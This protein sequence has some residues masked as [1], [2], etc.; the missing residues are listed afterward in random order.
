MAKL[1]A[2][3]NPWSAKG[4]YA[5][6]SAGC[7]VLDNIAPNGT[8]WANANPDVAAE[9]MKRLAAWR[10]Y[11][12]SSVAVSSNGT[13]VSGDA[14]SLDAI[15]PSHSDLNDTVL[16]ALADPLFNFSSLVQGGGCNASDPMSPLFRQSKHFRINGRCAECPVGDRS[17]SITG[18]AMDNRVFFGLWVI[19]LLALITVRVGNQLGNLGSLPILFNFFATTSLFAHFAPVEG[20]SP[21]VLSIY[22]VM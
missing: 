11:G 17:H 5:V 20:W 12:G 9:T 13:V 21:L 1:S 8:G 16:A 10:L 14:S 2:A 6:A 4:D 22:D 18:G 15:Y 7:D 19:A 3:N